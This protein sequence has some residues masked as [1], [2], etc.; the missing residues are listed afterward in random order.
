MRFR[1]ST[2][3]QRRPVIS[4][5]RIP[6]S[7]A[8]QK[9]R[10]SIGLLRAFTA[11]TRRRYSSAEIRRSR[12]WPGLGLRMLRTGFAGSRTRRHGQL[13]GAE[14]QQTNAGRRITGR[15]AEHHD[16]QQQHFHVATSLQ[17]PIV[18]FQP[19][20]NMRQTTSSASNSADH[21][22]SKPR[23][24]QWSPTNRLGHACN[25]QTAQHEAG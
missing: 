23:K 16:D 15:Q 7:V 5:E 9:T 20:E 2:C 14:I 11:A 8:I 4:D 18:T 24:Q 19:P 3:W 21:G 25:Q 6:V 10:P 13:R 17:N 22:R 12:S 1:R